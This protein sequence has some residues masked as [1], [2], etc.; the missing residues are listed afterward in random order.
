MRLVFVLALAIP[1]IL[2][3]PN[4]I[5]KPISSATG[6]DVAFLLFQ[7]AQ[8]TP[9]QYVALAQK[10]QNVTANHMKLWVTIPSAFLDLENPASIGVD[11]VKTISDTLDA[12]YA[13]KDFYVGGH[14]LGGIAVQEWVRDNYQAQSIKG[15]VLMGSTLMRKYRGTDSVVPTLSI[16][17][18][19][20]GLFRVTRM[21]EE[22]YN[23]IIH[24]T[25]SGAANTPVV[26][27]PGM[28]HFQFATGNAPTL[29]AARDLK[30]EADSE[31]SLNRA[32]SIIGNFLAYVKTGDQTANN[33][34]VS[35]VKTT[36]QFI[37]PI[38]SAFELEG[39]REFNAPKQKDGPLEDCPKGM[40]SG[41]GSVWAITAQEFIADKNAFTS[42]GLKLHVTNNYVELSSL[43]PFGE[44]HLPNITVDASDS[45]QRNLPTYSQGYWELLDKFDTGF[46]SVSATEIGTKM[47][48]RQCAYIRG[49]GIPESSAPFS[50]DDPN[51]CAQMNQQAYQWAI[52]NA[53]VST[54]D[55]FNRIGQ[56]YTFGDD[57]AKSGGPFWI[58]ARLEFN[59]AKDSSGTP[60]I[61]IV[62]PMIKTSI[63]FPR[64]PLLPDP[65]CYHYCKLLSPARAIEWIY[66]D[67]LRLKG[68]LSSSN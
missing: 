54:R 13:G 17:G 28:N 66:V 32:S 51:F 44:F 49:I 40:C 36:G 35:A 48:S 27:I 15:M 11:A 31:S 68:G 22:Y 39:S 10:I 38:V 2:G 42:H 25:T 4:Q 9:D 37:A 63:D 26:V 52:N 5:L 43:P 18:E 56:K 8:V 47:M 7:G 59:D 20:D 23:R 64:I 12:G 60:V 34:V 24:G 50:L 21:A 61:Q 53:G 30:P 29:V 55:R 45:K 1:A 65:A 3:S 46:V 6:P 62:S 41:I 16:A 58:N 33:V 67:S 14:S 19:L 57:V